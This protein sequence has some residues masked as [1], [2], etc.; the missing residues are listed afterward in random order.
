MAA[1]GLKF[2]VV[3]VDY[4][5]KWVEAKPLARIAAG[6]ITKF[7]WKDIVCRF[8]V[9]N[10]IVADN[11]KQFNCP[12]FI[13][14]MNRLGTNVCFA[15]VAYPQCNG[16][17]EA[18]NKTLLKCIEKR[19][20]ETTRS[21]KNWPEEVPAVLW[22]QRTKPNEA[23]GD[24]PFSLAF[25]SE[26]VLPVELQCLTARIMRYDERLNEVQRRVDLDLLERRREAAVMRNA[27][28][29]KDG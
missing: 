16:Q 27:I 10:A 26:A 17:V 1:G 6:D 3:A 28:T 14:F 15:S 18:V 13:E 11:G 12:E 20:L 8:G 4:F 7:V 25:G 29:D 2:L 23:T 5:T 24:S 19:L 22:A 21:K 9:P